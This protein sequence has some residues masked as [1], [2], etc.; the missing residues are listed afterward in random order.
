MDWYWFN[1]IYK[2]TNYLHIPRDV[3]ATDSNGAKDGTRGLQ[4]PN[5]CSD[6]YVIL[7]LKCEECHFSWVTLPF[8]AT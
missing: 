6:K 2:K 4:I 3:R 5:L 1:H 8:W 7:S